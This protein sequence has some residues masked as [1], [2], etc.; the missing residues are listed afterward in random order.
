[1]HINKITFFF[2]IIIFSLGIYCST[3]V[4]ISWD[5]P[6]SNAY[7]LAKINFLKTFGENKEYLK[8]FETQN[9]G[10]YTTI[11][12]FV[13]NL[14]PKFLVYEVRHLINLLISFFTI[15]G[16]YLLVKENFD[17]RLALLTILFVL[18]NPFF[19]GLMS[20]TVRDIPVCFA[21]IWTVYF[22][23]KYT[24][25]FFVKRIKYSILLG[26]AIGF[27][28]G[29]RVGFV[30]N[31]IPLFLILIFFLILNNK[32]IKLLSE[33]KNIFLDL[34]TI[35][36]FSFIILFSF[37]VNAYDNP[38]ET[39]ITTITQTL[40]LSGPEIRGSSIGPTMDII[41]DNIYET[42][43]TPRTYLLSFFFTR[44]PVFL[45]FLF[46]VSLIVI[47]KKK[48][49]F[50]KK[51]KNFSYKI[52]SNF[53]IFFCPIFLITFLS[54]NLYDGIRL[55]IFIIPFFSLFVS[56][57][58][59]YLIETYR[60]SKISKVILI[61]SFL[62]FIPFLERFVRLTPYQ[63]D[64]ANYFYVPFKNSENSFHH[65]Y[66]A[67]SYKEL[68]K[69]IKNDENFKNKKFSVSVCGG[70]IWQAVIEFNKDKEIKNNIS[71]YHSSFNYK[72]DYIIMINRLGFNKEFLNE[73]CFD[74]FKGKNIHSVGRLGIIYSVFRKI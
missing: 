19:F 35:T 6:S 5:E 48:D 44:F 30:V 59:Y 61:I 45:I 38:I 53:I 24:Q 17:K 15:V 41:N 65:D 69:K 32:R 74:R 26:L 58:F 39:L 50:L 47:I 49:F 70:D 34:I 3:I 4:G 37:W 28:L 66:W 27:G 64:F 16:I 21:Y 20:I 55:I 68:I 33:T 8:Y 7:S 46:L 29:A 42:K 10:F 71:Y 1:M 62:I 14:F 18:I 43:N 57:A 25:N 54:V 2:I 13:S 11:L 72:A 56:I 9:P 40:S 51:F 63:Y 36:F 23:F 52:N 60:N 12:A 67:I 22:F 73:K 31:L